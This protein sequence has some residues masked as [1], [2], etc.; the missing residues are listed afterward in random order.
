MNQLGIAALDGTQWIYAFT[1]A[2]FFSDNL[3][4]YIHNKQYRDFENDLQKT[5]KKTHDVKKSLKREPIKKKWLIIEA[6]RNNR[7][8]C[9]IFNKIQNDMAYMK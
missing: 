4:Y 2:N 9:E 3:T 8:N 6:R 5:Q 7:E 1:E